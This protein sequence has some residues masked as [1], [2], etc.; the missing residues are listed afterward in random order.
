MNLKI[1]LL[2]S[3]FILK[4]YLEL[5]FNSRKNTRYLYKIKYYKIYN[6]KYDIKDKYNY[7]TNNNIVNKYNDYK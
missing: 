7:S 3:W 2:N 4:P 6:N 1:P 5:L